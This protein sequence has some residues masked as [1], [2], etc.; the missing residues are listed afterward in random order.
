MTKRQEKVIK[1]E[2]VPVDG[3]DAVLTCVAELLKL[4]R[5][6]AV[7]ATNAIM[8]TTYWEIGR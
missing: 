3:Y 1:Q 2:A 6:T 4:A 7:R 8:T 5:H